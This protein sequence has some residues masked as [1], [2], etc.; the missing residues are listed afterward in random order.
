KSPRELRTIVVRLEDLN[1]LVFMCHEPKNK[2]KGTNALKY[3]EWGEKQ[4]YHKRPTYRGRER[5]WDLGEEEISLCGYPMVNY[6]RLIVSH[7]N[8]FYNDAN[9]VG[10]YPKNEYKNHHL[11][12]SLNASFNMIY[13]ELFGISNLGGGAIKQNPIY[14]KNFMVFNTLTFKSQILIKLDN[15][16]D[17]ISS[18]PIQS[19]FTELGFDPNK[20]IREQEPNPLPDRKALDDIVFDALGLTEEERKEVYYA[21]AE[22]VQNRL[23]KAKSV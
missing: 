23:K 12:I 11:T 13:W 6:D 22:L 16:F 1:H 4:G 17:K 14:F 7:N 20:P 10:I 9:I 3:I 21:V 8:K 2:L 15:I 18:R 19:I 5:W